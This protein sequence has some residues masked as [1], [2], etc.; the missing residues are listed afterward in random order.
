MGEFPLWH[1]GYLSAK[2]DRII[3]N[4]RLSRAAIEAGL[5]SFII[6][7]QFSGHKW[8]PIYIEDLLDLPLDTKRDMSSKVLADVVEALI[9]A[10]MVDGGIPKALRCLQVFIP[11]QEWRPLEIRRTYLFDRVPNVDLPATLQPLKDLIGYTF[12]KKALLVEAMT[13][14][15]YKSGS[16]SLE[17]LGFLG[18]AVLDYVIINVMFREAELSHIE[19]HHLR[20]SLVNSDYL[21]FIR[22]EWSIDQET[23]DLE[24]DTSGLPK[25]KKSA[26]KDSLW[27]FLRH[28]SPR[29]GAV[30]QDTSARYA[31]LRDSIVD[32]FEN[33]SHYPWALLAR[34]K[35]QKFFSDM[36]ESLLGAIWIDSGSFETCTAV[37]ECMGILPYF[38][39]ILKDKVE[40]LHPKEELGMLADSETVKYVISSKIGGIDASREYLCTVFVGDTRVIEVDGGVSPEEVKTKAAEMAVKSMKARKSDFGMNMDKV[41]EETA[42]D[43]EMR[44]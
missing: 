36:V 5:D 22:M 20:T 2:K 40:T 16:Q 11:E 1:E 37:V 4:S 26:R 6:T 33:G 13:H 35:A 41:D 21:A 31:D 23:I 9:G 43:I 30:Q 8:R 32:A 34:L 28:G 42:V 19:M 39:R 3:S 10:A 38:R 14:A 29:L 27:R 17:R 44:D 7:K 24:L 25:F 15:S 12:K 18:D